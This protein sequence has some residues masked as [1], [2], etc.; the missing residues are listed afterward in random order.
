MGKTQPYYR[1]YL[2]F[3]QGSFHRTTGNVIRIGFKSNRPSDQDIRFDLKKS[4]DILE[5]EIKGP[6]QKTSDTFNLGEKFS[7]FANTGIMKDGL[8]HTLRTFPKNLKNGATLGDILV[9][10]IDVED[11]FFIDPKTPTKDTII[12]E[13]IDADDIKIETQLEMWKYLKG[14]KKEPRKSKSGGYTYKFAEGKMV[15]PDALDKPSRT[16][17]TGEGG[18]SPSRFKHVIKT[19]NKLHPTQLAGWGF[20]MD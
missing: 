11:E 3:L 5:F 19:N 13:Q 12:R 15:F 20:S 16:I 1:S 9:D 4:G 18:P 6:P 10:D 2:Q 7:P 8:V 14:K 17:I